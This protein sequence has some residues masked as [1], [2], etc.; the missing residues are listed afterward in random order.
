M[1]V[2]VSLQLTSLQTHTF[3]YFVLCSCPAAMC[4][5]LNC[6]PAPGLLCLLLN[7]LLIDLAMSRPETSL[8]C[9]CTYPPCPVTACLS[10]VC[11]SPPC[12][13]TVLHGVLLCVL[14]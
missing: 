13:F 3:N 10:A 8:L 5:L 11:P 14:L 7:S 9:M 2:Y 4:L 12:L 1:Y 6:V